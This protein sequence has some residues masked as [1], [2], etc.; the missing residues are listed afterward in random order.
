[1]R[2]LEAEVAAANAIYEGER[3]ASSQRLNAEKATQERVRLVSHPFL[4]CFIHRLI[5]PLMD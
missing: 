4:D 1:V 3:E 5:D 2:A